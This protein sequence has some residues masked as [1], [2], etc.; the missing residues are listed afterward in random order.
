MH[1]CTVSLFPLLMNEYLKVGY[2]CFSPHPF[3]CL[4]NWKKRTKDNSKEYAGEK[5]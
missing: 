5:E 2:D 4:V 1:W 3:Q